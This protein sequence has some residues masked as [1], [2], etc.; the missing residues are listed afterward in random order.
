M[1]VCMYVDMCMYVYVFVKRL[2]L[3]SRLG[4]ISS[5]RYY[6][7][8][9]SQIAQKAEKESE[10]G[11]RKYFSSATTLNTD[12]YITALI[13]ASLYTNIIGQSKQ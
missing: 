8:I 1:Y 6:Y 11:F 13:L 3:F 7:Y 10:I 9:N 2:E 12:E 5:L 4:A